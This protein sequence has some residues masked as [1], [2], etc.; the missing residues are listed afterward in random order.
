[1]TCARA[2]DDGSTVPNSDTN[3]IGEDSEEEREVAATEGKEAA[4]RAEAAAMHTNRASLTAC[5][6][7]SQAAL[8]PPPPVDSSMYVLYMVYLPLLTAL[9]Y[10]LRRAA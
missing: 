4:L 10:H 5:E 6:M 8:R 9:L 7:V 1:M 2:S 3:N